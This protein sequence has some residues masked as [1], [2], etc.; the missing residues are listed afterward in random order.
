MIDGL[1]LGANGGFETTIPSGKYSLSSPDYASIKANFSDAD[2]DPNTGIVKFDFLIP[3]EENIINVPLTANCFSSTVTITNI[4]TGEKNEVSP[5]NNG[6]V[7][8][9]LKMNNR[10]LIEHNGRGDTISTVGL[11]P[12]MSIEGP[13]KFYVGQTW[14]I[15]NIY[16]DLDKWFIRK[17]AAVELDNLVR[18]MKENPTLEIEGFKLEPI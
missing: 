9:D 1:P 7:R 8:L 10:Y 2:V 18:V 3:R 15:H 17:D 4:K 6:E 12:G 14:I 5:N 13:C 11:K 16:Y